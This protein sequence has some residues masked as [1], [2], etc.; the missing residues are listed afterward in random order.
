MGVFDYLKVRPFTRATSQWANSLV[1]AVQLTYDIAMDTNRSTVKYSDL[2]HLGYD[3]IPYPDAKHLLGDPQ[4][5]WLAIYGYYGYF[6]ENLYVQ[7]RRVLKDGDP[8]N[9]YDIFEPAQQ[10]LVQAIEQGTSRQTSI[11]S[12]IY[13]E[14]V[15]TAELVKQI[16]DK[17]VK[18]SL[19]QYGNVGVIIAEP[20]DEY[21]YVKVSSQRAVEDA[22]SPV[23]AR[24]IV[25][26]ANNIYGVELAIATKGRPNINLYYSLGGAGTIYV[27]GSI[28]GVNWRTIDTITLSG[29]GEGVRIYQGIAFP[30]VRAR[31]PTSGIDVVLEIVA[32]R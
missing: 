32:S 23:T 4:Y 1:D 8:I 21:G 11:L 20:L 19:D 7:G 27:E 16:R 13:G 29:A 18:I 9:L 24:T 15:V 5:A 31:V 22:F 14:Q 6:K 30:F 25:T 28:D 26:A 12:D 3:I 10:K 17:V 2:S